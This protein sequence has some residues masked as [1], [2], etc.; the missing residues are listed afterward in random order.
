[1]EKIDSIF[2]YGTL[3]IG[4]QHEDILKSLKGTWKKAHV[5]GNL[6]NIGSGPDYGYPGLKLNKNGSKIYGMLL[7]S[8]K[9]KEKLSEIDEFEGESYKRIISKVNFEDGSNTEAYLYEL[10]NYEKT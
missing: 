7:K 2:V 4:K 8:K 1:M 3:Q 6:Y 9:L 5:R 10:K